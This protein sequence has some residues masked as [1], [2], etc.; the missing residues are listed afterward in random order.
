MKGIEYEVGKPYEITP[1]LEEK[2]LSIAREVG[3]KEE[4]V[5]KALEL[6]KKY[7]RKI[8]GVWATKGWLW[9]ATE[10]DT[11]LTWYGVTFSPFV[12]EGEWGS[13]YIGELESIGVEAKIKPVFKWKIEEKD[14][15]QL[16]LLK[17]ALGE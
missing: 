8:R 3:V 11:K 4:E 17:K 10:H 7:K 5:K 2:I 15:R 6:M 13:W 16:E 9:I 1:E 12:P 14:I